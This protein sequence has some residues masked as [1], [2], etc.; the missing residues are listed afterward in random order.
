M[1]DVNAAPAEPATAIVV[2]QVAMG[3]LTTADWAALRACCHADVGWHMP[4]RSPLAGDLV[5]V[6]PVVDRFQ[7]MQ[8]ATASDQPAE[9]VS[10]LAGGDHAAVVQRNWIQQ[11]DGSQPVF[12]AVTL[13]RVRDGLIVELW[14]LVSD[15]Y[16][17]DQLWTRYAP[18]AP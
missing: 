16:A 6:D 8:S 12:M 17:I 15:Q 10:V 1:D 4:G 7:R 5:G 2:L 11:P 13:A 14:S 9:L 3:A 18:P